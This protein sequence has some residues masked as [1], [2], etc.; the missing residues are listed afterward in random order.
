[1]MLGEAYPDL[2]ANTNFMELHSTVTEDKIT[3]TTIL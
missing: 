1:M 3:R 2:K